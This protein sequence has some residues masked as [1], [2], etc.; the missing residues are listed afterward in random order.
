MI[1][2]ARSVALNP[3]N[4]LKRKLRD[5]DRSLLIQDQGVACQLSSASEHHHGND[6]DRRN[7]R[8]KDRSGTLHGKDEE[9]GTLCRE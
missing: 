4:P 6:R 2:W 1:L 5:D 9:T 3:I 7:C 8:E